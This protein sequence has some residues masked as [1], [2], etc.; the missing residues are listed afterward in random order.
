[1]GIEITLDL[2]RRKAEHNAGILDDLQELSLHQLQIVCIGKVL[3]S[4][5][6]HLRILLL[7]NNLIPKI[8]T[9]CI[10]LS[11]ASTSPV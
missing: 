5:C 10:T 4:S 11:M 8:G 1:M 3:A 7:Q 9:L 2:I 6:R